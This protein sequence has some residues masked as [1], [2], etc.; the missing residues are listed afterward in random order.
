MQPD[1]LPVFISTKNKHIWIGKRR[2]LAR[3]DEAL[4]NIALQSGVPLLPQSTSTR[5]IRLYTDCIGVAGT[6]VGML[7]LGLIIVWFVSAADRLFRYISELSMVVFAFVLSMLLVSSVS[8][9]RR[10]RDLIIYPPCVIRLYQQ[11]IVSGKIAACQI[12]DIET[13]DD[14]NYLIR[15]Q[16]TLEQ[17]GQNVKGEYVTDR[18][19]QVGT[20]MVV[21]YLDA[22]CHVLL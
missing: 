16:F 20:K 11:L 17:N 6:L 2:E 8:Y 22:R 13:L 18:P 4:H 5:I 15:Y 21:L 9:A 1:S 7:V 12:Q 14:S 3:R 19:F 10:T